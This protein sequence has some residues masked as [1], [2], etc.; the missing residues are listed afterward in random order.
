M[1]FATF[2]EIDFTHDTNPWDSYFEGVEA[3]QEELEYQ[4]RM[5]MANHPT[6][7]S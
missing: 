4:R 3:Y 1:S 6:A 5:S 7:K 2:D